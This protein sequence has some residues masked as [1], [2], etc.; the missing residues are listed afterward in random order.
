MKLKAINLVTRREFEAWGENSRRA[1]AREV[2]ALWAKEEI[3]ARQKWISDT[4]T[5]IV[6]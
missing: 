6:K 5:R 4:K 3:R 1:W 2:N